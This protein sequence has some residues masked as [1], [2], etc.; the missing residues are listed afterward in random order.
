M[1]RSSIIPGL[2]LTT[3]LF[4]SAG[5]PAIGQAGAVRN[6]EIVREGSL[7]SFLLTF[8]T[9]PTAASAVITSEGLAVLVSGVDLSVPA[10]APPAGDVI[11][12]VSALNDAPGS[13]R[14]RLEGARFSAASATLYHNAVLVETRLS[15][16]QPT[17]T[18]ET[19]AAA[20]AADRP[21]QAPA[22][23]PSSPP[24]VS[25][26]PTRPAPP[27]S[28]PRAGAAPAEPAETP[29]APPAPA[30]NTAP[31]AQLSRAALLSGSSAPDCATARARLTKTPWD[32]P[33]LGHH[34]LCL[35][36]AGKLEDAANRVE[37]I[38]AFN[39]DDWRAHLARAALDAR[40]GRVDAAAQGFEKARA[41]ARD[42]TVKAAVKAYET[43]FLGKQSSDKT[44]PPGR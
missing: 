34:T 15:D 10:F 20:P 9:Q 16:D 22:Q 42:E 35:I 33:S 24:P 27:K 4:V 26:A 19:S 2:V 37:Q 39:P 7:V 3:L 12:T 29:G 21:V 5:A 31:E 13:T 1:R 36:E 32:M 41:A 28:G 18:D 38:A 23:A 6:I 44:E 40:Q 43:G 8:S 11:R 30:T 17:R 25:S 14:F